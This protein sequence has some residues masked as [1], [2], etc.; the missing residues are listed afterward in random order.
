MIHIADRVRERLPQRLACRHLLRIV[1]RDAAG[2]GAFCSR[3]RAS[4]DFGRQ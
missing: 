4:R 2:G 1:T 3:V